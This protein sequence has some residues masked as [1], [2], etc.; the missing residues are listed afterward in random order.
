MDLSWLV[1]TA[2]LIAVLFALYLIRDVMRRDSGTPA[3]Q[4]IA[5]RIL[6]G[7]VAFLRRQYRTI[8]ILAVVAAVAVGAVVG[9]LGGER[10]LE[11]Y[12]ITGIGIAWRTALAFLAG[13][14]CSG[15]S[16][17]IG[18]YISVKSNLRCAAAAAKGGLSEA[19]TVAIRGGAVSGFLIVALSLLGVAG[20]YYMYGGNP[21]V[22]PHL[23]IG[24]GFGASFVALF[25][26]LGGG[27]YTKAADMGADLVGKVEAGIPE[28]D[29]RNAAVIADLVGDNVGDCAGRGADLFESTAAENIGAMILGITLYLATGNAA[30]VLFPLVVRAFGILASIVGIMFVRGKDNESP[31]NALNRGYFTAVGLSIIGIFIANQTIGGDLWL[32]GAGVIGILTSVAMVF[33]TQYYTEFRYKPVQEIANASRTGAATNI[34]SGT[35]V[36]LETAMP[37]AITIGAA[38][39]LSYWMGGQTGIAG[40]AVFGTA[41]A[42]M[43]MLMTC[44]FILAMDTFGPITDNANGVIEM[45]GVGG[46]V[47]KITDRLD[48]VGNTTKALTKGYALASA[49]LAAFLLFEAYLERVAF[50]RGETEMMAVDLSRIEVFVGGLLAVALV[51]FFS[52]VAIKAVGRTASKI[53]EEVR[54]QFK[55]DPGIL[56]GTSRPDYARAVDITAAAGLREMIFPGLLPVLSPIVLG[57]FLK[58]TG[59]DSAMAIAGFLMVGTIGGIM[60]A[61]YLNNSGGAWDNAKKY[62]ETGEMLEKDG[63]PVLK[64]TVTHAAT[65]V[66]DTVGDPFKDTAGPSIHVLI[67]LLSTITLVLAPLFI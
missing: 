24:F 13:A 49:G 3:M 50:L 6:E 52:A 67:K 7:A 44:P 38:L 48:A 56:A 19:V 47:R 2:G 64:H 22:T 17:V 9:L 32:F 25:A 29:P 37:T 4:D 61:A 54:R 42:T 18:M 11:A 15:I 1:W 51:Y 59:Y 46:K 35:A 14:L 30:W 58:L 10:G 23:I 36:G 26:Q 39:L 16:G 45:A 40:G 8:A 66:G 62:I 57:V 65:V 31:M 55:A 33:I 63:S 41:A 5:G 12:G 43:G 20:I 34:V 60:M 28:D 21:E 53:I 27:I